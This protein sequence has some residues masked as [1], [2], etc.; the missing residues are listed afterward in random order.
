MRHTS[1]L[2]NAVPEGG[3]EHQ[4]AGPN[5]HHYQRGVRTAGKPRGT[6]TVRDIEK[7][8]DERDTRDQVQH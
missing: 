7:A 4:D 8:S 1:N 2:S 5:T 3:K 6:V